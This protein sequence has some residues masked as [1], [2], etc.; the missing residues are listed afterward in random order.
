MV[1][2]ALISRA[3]I[4]KNAAN[5]WFDNFFSVFTDNKNAEKSRNKMTIITAK[6]GIIDS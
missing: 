5:N 2:K 3:V 4:I 6:K 1:K